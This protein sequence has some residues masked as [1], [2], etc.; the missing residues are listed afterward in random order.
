[1]EKV[2]EFRKVRKTT[3]TIT[4]DYVQLDLKGLN[5][6]MSFG[7]KISKKIFLNQFSGVQIKNPGLTNGFLQFIFSGSNESKGKINDAI[8]DENTILFSKS[9]LPMALEIQRVIEESISKNKSYSNSQ[10]SSNSVEKLK[11]L[12]YLLDSDL[13]SFE[14]FE[15]KKKKIIEDL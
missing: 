11:E 9:E 1:M 14:E 2:F 7:G 13:I 6:I 15:A 5:N 3:V 4:D 10:T 8:K 12:K